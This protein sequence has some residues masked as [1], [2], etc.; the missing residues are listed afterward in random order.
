MAAAATPSGVSWLSPNPR[1]LKGQ[2]N[3]VTAR[4]VQ[5]TMSCRA[6]ERT[7]STASGLNSSSAA[8]GRRRQHQDSPSRLVLNLSLLEA[9]ART[10][11]EESKDLTEGD[12]DED[13]ATI[14]QALLHRRQLLWG[15][16][17]TFSYLTSAGFGLAAPVPPANLSPESC[18]EVPDQQQK[19][20][21]CLPD[22][23]QL[24][25]IDFEFEADLP[26]R[27]RQPAHIL[28]KDEEY[29]KKYNQAYVLMKQLPDDDPR[30]FAAQWH[31]HCAFCEGAYL[32]PNNP[33]N[34]KL[35]YHGSW[36]F[37]PWHRMYLYF[38]ERILGD[39]IGDP[40]FALPV[41]NW[42]NQRDA[43]GGNQMPRMFAPFYFGKPL[44][45][46]PQD[47]ELSKAIRNPEHFPPEHVRLDRGNYYD[48][49]GTVFDSNLALMHRA[50]VTPVSST[51]FLGKPYRAGQAADTAGPGSIEVNGHNIVH[52]WTGSNYLKL[53][54]DH[55]DMGTFLY[56]A[57]DP[58]FYSHH[59]NV[60]RMW[61][62]WKILQID[63]STRRGSRKREDPTD[64]DFLNTQ[65]A[66]YNHKKQ[67][68]HVKISQTLDTERLRYKYQ[69]LDS[70]QDWI[71]YTF[72]DSGQEKPSPEEIARLVTDK[73]LK[74]DKSVSFALTRIEP[75]PSQGRSAE[76]LEETLVVKGV[77]VPKNSF[78]L[79]KV[80][81]NLPDAGVS[82][83]L[84]IYNFVGVITHVPHKASHGLGHN[85]KVDFR[86]S[87]G[88]SLKALGIKDL[89]QVSVTFV[90]GGQEDDV[91]FD[92]VDVEFN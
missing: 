11:A 85:R 89:E 35:Q 82:T 24:T 63:Q 17:G 69:A 66:F 9:T 78:M 12:E 68:V 50:V 21:C 79:Y 33:N 14:P 86:L 15:A 25:P 84:G 57:R 1:G 42:D 20:N 3:Q 61:T 46:N 39:L 13:D 77:Q 32:E 28:S 7:R 34:L 81:I 55:E 90:P 36:T 48:D 88:A 58:I 37:L 5:G 92:G 45:M 22:G 26:M 72:A 56:A 31:I 6:E 74:K 64:P 59:S 75:T 87:I 41:W 53:R 19:L 70:D 10:G 27:I 73:V 30:S 51:D 16:T 65:F 23:S 80:F 67:L 54:P 18:Q 38:H 49:M 4:T 44:S 52:V 2:G 29:V 91:E 43:D 47:S 71:N 62:V 40:E 8:S 76:D 83:P 60:D